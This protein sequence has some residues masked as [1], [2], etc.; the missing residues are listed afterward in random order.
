MNT[1]GILLPT[2]NFRGYCRE[3]LSFGS[4]RITRPQRK[5]EQSYLLLLKKNTRKNEK[6]ARVRKGPWQR[7][8]TGDKKNTIQEAKKT[9]KCYTRRS[10]RTGAGNVFG[11]ICD[12]VSD[13]GMQFLV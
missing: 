5:A 6:L 9:M 12:T 2:N 8:G 7:Q 4:T 11:N 1:I 10:L 13:A 3:I